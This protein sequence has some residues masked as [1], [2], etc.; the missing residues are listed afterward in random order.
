MHLTQ[1]LEALMLSNK[2]DDY[3]GNKGMEQVVRQ[4]IFRYFIDSYIIDLS[5]IFH[6]VQVKDTT[7]I[8]E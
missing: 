6:A 7:F 8:L 5:I 1:A 4:V 2:S 3:V